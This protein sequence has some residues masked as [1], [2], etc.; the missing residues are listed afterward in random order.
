MVKKV[1]KIRIAPGLKRV[2]KKV[3]HY[4]FRSII[5]AGM[6]SAGPP[7]GPALGQVRC[8][9]IIKS[10]SFDATSTTP[11]LCLQM[12]INI[13]QFCKEFN[14]KTKHMKPGVPVTVRAPLNPD[15]SYE[16]KV[17]TP[18][19]CYF[20]KQAAGINKGTMCKSLVFN[21]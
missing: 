12:N 17:Y 13:A 5:P 8:L 18:T 9:N 15:R 19:A 20:L 1:G 4:M 6:A 21:C 14:E 2:V 3:E 7:L 11:I 10:I 16:M